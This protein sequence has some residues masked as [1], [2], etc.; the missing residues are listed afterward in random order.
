MAEPIPFSF[1]RAAA[2]DRRSRMTIAAQHDRPPHPDPPDPREPDDDMDDVP[3]TPP[4]EP[5]PVPIRDPRPDQTP[6][7]PYVT[8]AGR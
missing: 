3:E 2:G 5:P 7:G 6:P 4:T 8:W 1:A